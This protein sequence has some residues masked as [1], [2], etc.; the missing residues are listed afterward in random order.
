MLSRL[1]KLIL[2][3]RR[4]SPGARFADIMRRVNRTARLIATIQSRVG[5][6]LRRSYRRRD[7]GEPFAK[8]R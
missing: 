5:R 7:E 8:V 2:K 6:N 1:R 3:I 4:R